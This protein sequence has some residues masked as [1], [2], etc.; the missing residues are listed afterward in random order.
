MKKHTKIIATISDQ[1]CDVDFI[2]NLYKAGMNVVRINTAHQMPEDTLKIVK[3]V[4][5]ISS[6]IPIIIDTKGPEVR[7]TKVTEKFSVQ[8]GEK[9]EIRGDKNQLSRPG[10][11]YVNYNHFID[12]IPVNSNILFDDGE[13]RFKVI[14]KNDNVLHCIVKN[15][16]IISNKKSINVPGVD[17]SLPSLNEKDRLYIQFAIDNDIEF[18]AHSFVRTKEDILAIQKILDE[19]NSRVKIIAKIENQTGVN[20]IDEILD[21]AYGIMIA[22][23]DLGVEICSAKIPGIQLNITKKCIH[24][25]KPVIVATQMLHSMIENPR[26]TRAEISDIATAIYR[27]TDAIMLSG[28]TAY[29]KYPLESVETMTKVANE[30]EECTEAR[31]DIPVVEDENQ[32]AVFLAKSAVKAS[33]KLDTKAIILDTLTGR[34]ARFVSAFRG[35]NIIYAICYDERVMRELGLSYGVYSEH[36]EERDTTQI[37]KRNATSFL[38]KKMKYFEKDDLVTLIGGNFG[39]E[40]GATFMEINTIENLMN[41]FQ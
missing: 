1:R 9:I 19:Q 33:Q 6:K 17:L 41:S 8:T 2:K 31:K 3:N 25:K 23:G 11:I 40:Q 4:R 15:D 32:I 27:G 22:R 37:I 10:C 26:A 7:T 30:F 39:A 34:T 16:G 24:R 12:D 18:I 20:N 35:R 14:E 21:Y 29:G 36:F 13:I 38:H 5:E 28:E